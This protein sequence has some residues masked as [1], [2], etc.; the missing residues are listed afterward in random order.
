M[1]KPN[2]LRIFGNFLIG[3]A[4]VTFAACGP[5][6]ELTGVEYSEPIESVLEPDADG[7]VEDPRTGLKFNVLALQEEETGEGTT[8]ETPEVRVI[9]NFEGYYF[10]T[11]PGYRNVYVFEPV[12]SGL[13]LYEIIEVD[14]DGITEPAFNQRTPDIELLDGPDVTYRLSKDGIVE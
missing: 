5:S 7:N 4:I 6:L 13:D 3:M 11:A 14:E 9:R 12:E 8:V 2:K 1:V 10:I